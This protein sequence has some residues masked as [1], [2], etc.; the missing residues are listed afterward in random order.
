MRLSVDEYLRS[1][2]P[3]SENDL[4]LKVDNDI[5]FEFES[6]MKL[7]AEETDDLPEYNGTFSREDIYFDHD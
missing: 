4:G 2:L 6:D 1:I 7:F 3:K 5:E